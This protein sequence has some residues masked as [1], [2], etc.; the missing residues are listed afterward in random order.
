M[1]KFMIFTFLIFASAILVDQT[2]G[3]IE[4]ET[5]IVTVV[6]VHDG[7]SFVFQVNGSDEYYKA[8]LMAVDAAGFGEKDYCFAIYAAKYLQNFI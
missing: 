4:Y 8:Q 2:Q 6:W 3:Q 1:K 7:D 5:Q